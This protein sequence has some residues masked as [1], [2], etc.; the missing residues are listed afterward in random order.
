[1]SPVKEATVMDITIEATEATDVDVVV[2]GYGP[3]GQFLSLRLARQ[4]Y[5]VAV[6]ERWP[7]F[8]PLPRAV[9]FDDEVARQLQEIGLRPDENPLVEPYE[10]YYTWRNAE[11]KDLLRIDWRTP[12]RA[13]W[14]AANFFSQPELESEL[15]S[16]V[17]KEPGVQVFRGWQATHI[18]EDGEGVT[19]VTTRTAPQNSPRTSQE[20]AQQQA[21]GDAAEGE[22]DQAP[23]GADSGPQ[24][25]TFRGRYLVG[26][27]G[28]NSFVREHMGSG[29]EDLGFEFDWLIVDMIPDEPVVFDPP[30]WQWCNPANPTTIVPSGPGRR[31][32]EFMR[33]PHETIQEMNTPEYAW[34][35]MA[36]WGLT[37]DNSTMERHAVYTFRARWAYEWRRGRLLLAGDAAHLMP[38]FAGQGMCAGL[39]DAGNLVWRLDRVLSGSSPDALL[40]SYGPERTNHVRY[41]INFS[42]FLGN[43]ICITDEQAAAQRDAQMMAALDDPSLAPPPPTPPH[44]AGGLQGGH[45]QAGYQSIQSRVEHGGRSGLF[46]DV[47]GYGWT[48]LSAAGAPS[49]VLGERTRQWAADTGMRL[50]SL[51]SEDADV[52]DLDGDYRRWFD[53]L[54]TEAVV[55]RPDFSIYDAVYLADLDGCLAELAL[56]LEDPA[57]RDASAAQIPHATAST[58]GTAGP[59][60]ERD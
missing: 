60:P 6:V 26:C 38:P 1:M 31:R 49:R 35:R 11:Q 18:T 8:Y 42:M 5:S 13:G 25:R 14:P 24:Q 32:W 43:V 29:V 4:G 36:E 40:D 30:A 22:V 59:V 47:L 50:L 56:R 39:R 51:G 10:N 12:G 2:V 37:P 23:A 21:G 45:P 20:V 16:L 44:L 48:V 57:Q 55:I 27:D 33:M 17:E 54:G 34:R 41:F 52:L 58:S 3:V 19:L 15:H 7:E 28:A 46:D 53:E 9:V